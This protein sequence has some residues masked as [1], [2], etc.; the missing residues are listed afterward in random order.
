MNDGDQHND[1]RDVNAAAEEP[2]RR[3]RRSAPATVPAAAEREALVVLGAEFYGATARLA[4]V[5]R[6][7]ELGAAVDASLTMLR[8]G[9]IAI[10]GEQEVVE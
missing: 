8:V 9:E 6:H 10:T 7:I 5:V 2:Q 4:L 1:G 3:R